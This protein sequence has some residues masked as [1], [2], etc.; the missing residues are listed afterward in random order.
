MAET[1]GR[2]SPSDQADKTIQSEVSRLSWRRLSLVGIA[3]LPAFKF[4]R[5]LARL[6]LLLSCLS[7]KLTNGAIICALATERSAGNDGDT[8]PIGRKR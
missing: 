3:T 7:N 8:S 4:L 1:S 2:D 6:R 5:L